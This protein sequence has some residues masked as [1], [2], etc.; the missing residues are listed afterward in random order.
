[1]KIVFVIGSLE[2]GGAERVLTLL[3][4]EL[5][6]RKY[7][8]SIITIRGKS[9][10]PLNENIHLRPIY[11]EDEIK[12]N[13]LN[14]LKR[15]VTRYTR[16][17]YTIHTEKPDVVISFMVGMNMEIIPICKLL[18]IPIIASEHNNYH[19]HKSFLTWLTR[20]WIYKLAN[21]IT[22]LTQ[23]DYD[24]YY[25]NFLNNVYIMLNPSTYTPLPKL[26]DRNK[27]VILGV[28]SLN[29]W[30]HKGFDN[31]IKIFSKVSKK[32]PEW[33]LH[34]AGTGE[35]G[36]A[37]LSK[38]I[39]ENNLENKVKF[40][41]FINNIDIL[42][43]SVPIF[44]LSSR[45][46]GFGMV[47]VE[48]MSQ[49]ATCISYDCIAGPSEIIENNVDGLLIG[50]QNEDAMLEAILQLIEN[51]ELRIKLSKNAL[52]SINKFSLKII[53]DKWSSLITTIVKG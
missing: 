12:K 51:K 16:L 14:K 53:A 6:L 9:I 11:Q 13:L 17:A 25:K 22:I 41:G 23:Y 43:Q 5:S 33:E 3:A 35:D 19:T 2:G 15:R 50:D 29:R 34:L 21:A 30:H 4:N 36:K 32:H 7:E 44:V 42:M 40:L 18:N 48:A 28:G 47:L 52:K 1:M 26:N 38:I 8:I 46:E 39:Q 45:Y 37:Y 24:N 27:K 49:G 20:R 31:L 10:Y